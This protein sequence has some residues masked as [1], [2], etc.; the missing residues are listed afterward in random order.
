MEPLFLTTSPHPRLSTFMSS[1]LSGQ[2]HTKP[3]PGPQQRTLCLHPRSSHLSL[4][5]PL[6]SSQFVTPLPL[7]TPCTFFPDAFVPAAH[8]TCNG[9]SPSVKTQSNHQGSVPMRPPRPRPLKWVLILQ[10]RCEL[11][12]CLSHNVGLKPFVIL[13]PYKP[14]QRGANTRGLNFRNLAFHSFWYS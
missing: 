5:C 13:L 3:P 12:S 10:R 6:R 9:P 11:C 4:P 8:S 1:S 14:L 7:H 2:V